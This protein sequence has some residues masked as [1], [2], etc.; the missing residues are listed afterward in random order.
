MKAHILF[1]SLACLT[2]QANPV[3]PTVVAGDVTFKADTP[4]VLEIMTSDK[5]VINWK[6]FSIGEKELTRFIQPSISSMVLNRVTTGIRSELLGRLEANGQVFL[7][8]PNGIF[9]GEN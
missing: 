4:A 5:A 1:T 9:L 3:A 6:D 2:L 8:N 7:V